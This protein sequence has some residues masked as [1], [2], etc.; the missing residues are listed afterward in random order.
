M[1]SAPDFSLP[2]SYDNYCVM[3][4]PIAHSQSPFIHQSF[5][6]QSQQN[7][8]YSAF[9]IGEGEF[10]AALQA[11]QE[12]GGLGLNVTVPFKVDAFESV[13]R[14]SQR[15]KHAGAVN[16]IWFG[17]D[18]ESHGD[19][20]DG[21]GLVRDLAR[22][23]S[24]LAGKRLLILGAGGAVRG[25]IV[26]LFEAGT[27]SISLVNRTQSKAVELCDLF[28]AHGD[29]QAYSYD[30]LSESIHFDIIIN[31]TSAGLSG[32]VPPLP[33]ALVQESYC[34]DMIYAAQPTDFMRWAEVNGAA[35]TRDG[36]GMLVEQAAEAFQIW[37]GIR[38]ET[39]PV[40][41]ALRKSLL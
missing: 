40:L 3:G 2:D 14:H 12:Q 36:L 35:Q 6:R 15:A 18:G 30:E 20:T 26:S 37:R 23:L 9:Q 1:G 16:T 19:N 10:G 21:V 11:F 27:S 34:Y 22:E 7:I 32:E 33:P 39:E 28:S 8:R 24:S 5:A 29:M 13:S 31:A 4:N 17:E 38:P 41:A 25:V